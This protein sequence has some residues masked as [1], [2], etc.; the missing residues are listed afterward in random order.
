MNH[1]GFIL[2]FLGMGFVTF[3]SMLNPDAA[4]LSFM[5][6]GNIYMLPAILACLVSGTAIL[7]Y[8][9][10][11]WWGPIALRLIYEAREMWDNRDKK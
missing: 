9:L 11:V 4:T 7:L 6:F 3:L 5:A 10:S 1:K 2:L 8:G